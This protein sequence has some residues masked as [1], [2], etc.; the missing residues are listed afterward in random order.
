MGFTIRVSRREAERAVRRGVAEIV[1]TKDA[2]DV[3]EY[4]ENGDY[5]GVR[6]EPEEHVF[7][8]NDGSVCME[9]MGLDR[10][11]ANCS[12]CG[13][14]VTTIPTGLEE[15]GIRFKSDCPWIRR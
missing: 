8:T 9:D 6:H 15:N 11:W 10:F 3:D 5:A 12:A 2:R 7:R 13:S 1:K 14:L 4:D